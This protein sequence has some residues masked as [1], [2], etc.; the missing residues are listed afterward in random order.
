M[1]QPKIDIN[2]MVKFLIDG[3]FE[4]V[5]ECEIDEN[6]CSAI[7]LKRIAK[8]LVNYEL[9]LKDL[10]K[11]DYQEIDSKK[12]EYD[13]ELEVI[14]NRGRLKS[15]YASILMEK[16]FDEIAKTNDLLVAQKQALDHSA[17][18][19]ETD[20]S[21]KI[22]YVNEKFI[23][24]SKYTKE[25]LIGKD[26]RILN[27][28][29]HSKEF[30]I[31]LWKT[32]SRGDVWHAE[33]KN[34]DKNGNYYWVDTTI[35]PIKDK[36]NRL[37]KYV[38]IR[39][40]ITDKKKAMED[41]QIVSEQA[42]IAAK[43]KSEFLANMSHEIRT[44]MNA[45]IGMSELLK[46][47]PL[48][49]DQERFV[50]IL[51]HAGSALLDL[52][53]NI[54]DFSK[55]E[56]GY[57]ELED[58]QFDLEEVVF[59]TVDIM[60]SSI[61][62]KGLELVVYFDSSIPVQ[63]IGDPSRF[64]QVLINLLGNAVKFTKSG[65]IVVK[66]ESCKN[67]KDSICVSVSDTGIGIPSE[68]IDLIF[69]NFSQVNSSVS[70]EYGG[71][72][73]GLAISK[74]I[75]ELMNGSIEV[76]SVEGKGSTFHFSIPLKPVSRIHLNT[77][78]GS[79]QL[80]G[81]RALVVDDNATNRLVLRE[82]LKSWDMIIDDVECGNEA[83]KK[84]KTEYE[85]GNPFD[86]LILDYRMPDINGIE[87]ARTISREF[88][89]HPVTIILLTSEDKKSDFESAMRIGY[90]TYLVKPIRKSVLLKVIL[91][92]FEQ[93]KNKPKVLVVDDDGEILDQ[94]KILVGTLN[95]DVI[96]ARS[97][98]DAFEI[99][100]DQVVDLI[101]SDEKMNGMSGTELLKHIREEKKDIPFVLVSGFID[102][103]KYTFA[104]SM[105]NVAFVDKPFEYKFFISTIE[106]YLDPSYKVTQNVPVMNAEVSDCE[107][108]KI[109]VVDDVKDNCELIRAYLKNFPFSLE[110][111]YNG[112]DALDLFNRFDYDLIFMDVQ[113]PG[114]DG[115]ETIKRIRGM[116]LD[117]GGEKTPIVGLS[118]HA[119][120]EEMQKCIDAGADSYLTKP[121][122]KTTLI[123]MIEQYSKKKAT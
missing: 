33:V 22:T 116:E 115:C 97:G 25:E 70:R 28:R 37:Q 81:M 103:D 83:V 121:I 21:G 35:F 30:F 15:N 122:K 19:A 92:I 5:L 98:K 82:I 86:L 41:L 40:D 72:G 109:L 39:F 3:E 27:S 24:I 71:S 119:L 117:Q 54:L 102:P 61:H 49:S 101:I 20:L 4:S 100:K 59:S 48:N 84:F 107:S 29:F 74:K 66:V 14:R 104:K 51:N 2:Q 34:K 68:K 44:P 79:Q 111:A 46:E 76:E 1:R 73:L 110:F 60:C 43:V 91:S 85:K 89:H 53:N 9:A 96:T 64:R 16:L 12:S 99:L 118:A 77:Q 36:R 52:I 58:I 108:M 11:M 18:V 93:K 13:S 17:I 62:K 8:N 94:M 67:N 123:K 78:V 63:V 69:K 88:Q 47:T 65:E 105:N 95:V 57:L 42:K 112:I 31:D 23:Q 113:M 114:M 120:S 106:R 26:H 56:S 80:K 50:N 55:I 6:D 10:L 87:V 75:V 90:S 45:I 7:G 32:I 38:V